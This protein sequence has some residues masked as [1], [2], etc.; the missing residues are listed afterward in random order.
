[1]PQNE[2]TT[3]L[4]SRIPYAVVKNLGEA[5]LTTYKKE[6]GLD[7][8]IFRYFNTY[9]P[10]QSED[11]VL[12]RFV[13]RAMRNEDICVY[14]DGSQTRTFSYVDDTVDSCVNA[15]FN[16]MYVNEIVNIGGG[17]EITILELARTVV[18]IAESRSNIVHL[19]PLPEGD[20]SRRRPDVRKMTKLLEREPVSIEDGI[21]RLLKHYRAKS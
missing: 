14:G 7:Y 17:R 20:M 3:P 1:M 12:P 21:R 19:P 15:L 11:F 13:R 18:R 4:N 8:V 10:N 9:G 2:E 5:Y 16:D 6:F